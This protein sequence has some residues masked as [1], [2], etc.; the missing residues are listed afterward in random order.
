MVCL[1]QLKVVK[2]CLPQILLGPFLN[3]LSHFIFGLAAKV[4]SSLTSWDNLKQNLGRLKLY[5]LQ[6]FMLKLEILKLAVRFCPLAEK[7]GASQIRN[8]T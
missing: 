1:N 2:N 7:L 3:T 4:L 6:K 8:R 5:F